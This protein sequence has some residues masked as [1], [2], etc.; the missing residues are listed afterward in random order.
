NRRCSLVNSFQPRLCPS[1]GKSF[2][3]LQHAEFYRRTT[4]YRQAFYI[5]CFKQ[6]CNIIHNISLGRW[7]C[8]DREQNRHQNGFKGQSHNVILRIEYKKRNN[9][10]HFP[11]P[12]RYICAVENK[13]LA[14]IILDGWRYGKN[15]RSNAVQAASTPFF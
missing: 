3:L 10:I 8:Y 15:D 1:S 6:G 14:L 5:S 13:K 7:K 4:I 2:P 11:P 12:T 9:I